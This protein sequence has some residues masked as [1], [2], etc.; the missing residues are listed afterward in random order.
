MTCEHIT[1]E[2]RRVEFVAAANAAIAST[3]FE[4]RLRSEIKPS[5]CLECARWNAAA[6][7]VLVALVL[8]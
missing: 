5:P 4:E 1:E 8:K 7:G 6:A 2:Q 3:T